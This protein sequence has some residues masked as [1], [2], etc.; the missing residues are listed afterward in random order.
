MCRD[1][2]EGEEIVESKIAIAYCVDAVGGHFGEAEVAGDSFPVNGKRISGER[3]G[4]HRA[5]VCAR[6]RVL[7]TRDVASKCLGMGKEKMRK[8][9]GLRVLH[10]SHAGH[11]T[12]S[13]ALACERRVLQS[14]RRPRFT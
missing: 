5:S 6:R 12:P 2:G 9:N 7:E 13:L 4:P 8:Q 11:G 1:P 3:A 10:V 14:A